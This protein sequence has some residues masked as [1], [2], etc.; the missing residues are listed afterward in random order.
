MTKPDFLIV[1]A[2]VKV[3]GFV[4]IISEIAESDSTIMV[5]VE[6]AKAARRFQKPDWLN[7]TDAPHL[8]EPATWQDFLNDAEN[9]K[10]AA[11]KSVD[12]IEKYIERIEQRK[13]SHTKVEASKR[14]AIHGATI[15][16]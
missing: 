12:A 6:S 4:G 14:K 2:F 10:R 9:E 3:S 5:K 1:G 13:A 8:W 7:F 11:L 15:A 16:G